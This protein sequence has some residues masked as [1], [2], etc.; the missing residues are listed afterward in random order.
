M[1][2]RGLEEIEAILKAHKPELRERFGVS[3]IV[4]SYARGETGKRAISSKN[5]SGLELT[6]S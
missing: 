5:F 3:E 2:V 4:G 6:S 1:T